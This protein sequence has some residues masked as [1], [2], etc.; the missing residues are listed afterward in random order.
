MKFLFNISNHPSEQF[1]KEQ[2]D[3][4]KMMY[5]DVVDFGFPSIDADHREEHFLLIAD[6]YEQ[7]VK[8]TIH[9]YLEKHSYPTDLFIDVL[10]MG[11]FGMTYLLINKMKGLQSYYQKAMHNRVYLD[12]KYASTPRIAVENEDGSVTHVFKFYTYRRYM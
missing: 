8:D 10:V 5:D 1:K 3:Y 12:V 11:E 6:D 7:K 9:E 4:N 2:K